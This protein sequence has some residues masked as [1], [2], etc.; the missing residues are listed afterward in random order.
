VVSDAEIEAANQQALT[1][2]KKKIPD[3]KFDSIP[4]SDVIDFF[5]DTTGA[6]LFVN[7][8]ALEQCGIDRNM[9]VTLRL[10]DASFDTVLTAAIRQVDA[11]TLALVI[12]RGVITVT[13]VM[14]LPGYLLTKTYD[15]KQLAESNEDMQSLCNVVQTLTATQEV[16]DHRHPRNP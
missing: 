7:W 16:G 9:Q 13:T 5:R 8:K 10:N 11:Q 14:D 4:F 12:D 1:V 3:V 15:V 2:L 6:N